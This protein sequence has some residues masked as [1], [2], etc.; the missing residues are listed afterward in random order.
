MRI[1]DAIIY[2]YVRNC[3][4]K[5]VYRRKRALERLKSKASDLNAMKSKAELE[6]AA[7]K[8]RMLVLQVN[9]CCPASSLSDLMCNLCACV[10]QAR[11]TMARVGYQLS[12]DRSKSPV[13]A[14]SPAAPATSQSS[15]AAS[16]AIH[17][18][19]SPR[20]IRSIAI[21]TR[22]NNLVSRSASGQ[23]NLS[24][25]EKTLQY[26][27]DDTFSSPDTVSHTDVAEQVRIPTENTH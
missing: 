7:R 8:E 24:S 20:D 23:S 1:P 25:P 27:S 4:V 9:A 11:A 3:P 10:C 26:S 22:S 17:P 15:P 2:V 16:R 12:R 21:D 18:S 6:S 14:V 19:P 5:C 13:R